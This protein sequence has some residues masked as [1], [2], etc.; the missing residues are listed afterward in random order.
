MASS[1]RVVVEHVEDGREGLGADEV[2]LARA[3]RRW[4]A[5]RRRRPAAR[6][7]SP[8]RRR[9]LAPPSARRGVER[10][11]HPVERARRRSAGRRACRARAGRRW[12]GSRRPRPA[13]RPARRAIERWTIRR[14]SEVQRWPAVPTA[15][16]TMART[17]MSRS[18]E[19]A[20]IMALLPPSSRMARPKR[21]ATVGPD[22]AAHAGRAGGR[23]DGHAGR[24]DQRLADLGAADDELRRGRRARRRSGRGR[25]RAIFVQAIA[26]SGV[27]SD[28]FQI[29]G[30]P[31]TSASA[32]FHDQ[33][34]TGKLKAV[35]TAQGPSGCQVSA[36]RWPGRS[37]AM[38]RPWSWRDRPTAKSQMSIIS[39]TSPRPSET[40]LPASSVT[41]G[42]E[43]GLGGAQLL[44]EQAD[45]LAP[46][47][48]RHL[49]A[50]RR[51]RPAP[52]RRCAGTSAGAVSATRA[53]SA[54][55]MGERTASVPPW[56][57][58]AARPA[59]LSTSAWVLGARSW[60]FMVGPPASRLPSTVPAEG[61]DLRS[62]AR[63]SGNGRAATGTGAQALCLSA[64]RRFLFR[65]KSLALYCGAERHPDR[66][67][68]PIVGI[69][70][71]S[72]LIN[73]QYPT[74]AVGTMIS[75]AV[76]CV[77][78]AVPLV[79]PADPTVVVGRR[80]ARRLRRLSAA[81][82]AAQ[83]P[84]RGVRRGGDRGA[85]RLRPRAR[86]HCA[87]ADSRLR[88]A[89]AA[90]PGHLPRLSGGQRRPRRHAA[91]RDPRD[92]RADEP[93][94]AA[95][96]HAGGEVRGAPRRDVRRGRP[97]PRPLRHHAGDD[98]HAARAGD[99]AARPAR[100]R[101]RRCRR[102]HRGGDLRRGRAG[103]RP[104]G[105]VAPGV[106]RGHRPGLA[107]ALRGVRRGVPRLG[108]RPPRAPLLRSA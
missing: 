66:P 68:R 1:K 19:G 98:E 76:G 8:G 29:T 39:C 64:G 23:D 91:P 104:V 27:F 2:A 78:D 85:R 21:A 50:R 69:I 42:A 34:A 79:V 45:Q 75:H 92:P 101:R 28:G 54:P 77:A 51:T 6:L 74:H 35:T 11:L 55:S 89:R 14:R 30:S 48:R 5:R 20:T 96:R 61:A 38:V 60:S 80:P 37:E 65:K 58:A 90:G 25:G 22:D 13:A 72:H 12:A 56:R 73:D 59:R 103:L 87:A 67:M 63:G 71:N 108:L 47:R 24:A 53:T 10:R 31:Q 100:H 105:A 70:G 16:K 17:A 82:R 41:S 46:A 102:R 3:S 88:R 84:P 62:C 40:I 26:V 106:S 86:R 94:H 33:T 9:G 15:E 81:G 44:A 93:P 18:A 32:A 107:P 7:A 52:A 99:R 43:L 49:R 36:M 95:R 97:V 4:R 57:S 83:R